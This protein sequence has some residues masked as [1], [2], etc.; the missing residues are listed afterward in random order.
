MYPV[1][2]HFDKVLRRIRKLLSNGHSAEA[3]V[4]SVFTFEKLIKRSL[5]HAI[6]ARGFT[7][8]Q[9]SI[10]L[11]RKGFEE[12][13]RMWE[14]FERDHKRLPEIL[15]STWQNMPKAKTMRNHLVHGNK[16]YSLD[17]CKS[18]A[19][20]VLTA[21]EK[22]HEYV[23]DEYGADPWTKRPRKRATPPWKP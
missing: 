1:K 22:L 4:T 10:L 12:L 9:V 5:R 23:I 15:G 8:E 14:V 16:V 19:R 2:L 7:V 20:D 11:D 18:Y 3:L 17:D 13:Q 21:L 6:V